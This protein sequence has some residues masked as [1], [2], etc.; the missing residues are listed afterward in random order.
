MMYACERTHDVQR[1]EQW[2]GA[3]SDVMRRKN[4]M[5]VAGYCRAHYA[6]VLISAGRWRDAEI[7]MNRALDLLPPGTPVRAS[8]LCRLA[9]LRVRQG[10]FEEA[11]L[12]LDGLEVHDDATLP[13]ARLHADQGRPALAIEVLDRRLAAGALPDY[14]EVAL[15]AAKVECHLELGELDDARRISEQ[16]SEMAKNLRAPVVHALAAAARARV[17][18]AT[19]EGDAR[20]CW[21]QA[22]SLYAGIKMAADV[23]RCRLELAR[24]L[25]DSRPSVAI[26]EA[27][28]ALSAFESCGAIRAADEAAAFL[29]ELGGPARTGPKRSAPLTQREEEVLRLVAHGL[30]NAEIANRLCIS[31]KT[32]EHHVSRVLAKLGLRRRSEAA[33]YAAR[34]GPERTR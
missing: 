13:L 19:D 14:I 1:A 32:V 17:C 22:I 5:T 33:A 26:A 23:A 25:A 29:R 31:A 10:K 24:V 8:A 4:L 30:T 16:V 11:A 7:E 21:H 2:L 34:A 18:S 20:E 15:L 27:S 6:G 12:L 9:D 28:A 3:A